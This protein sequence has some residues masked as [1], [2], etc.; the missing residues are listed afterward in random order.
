MLLVCASAFLLALGGLIGWNRWVHVPRGELRQIQLTNNS[1]DDPVT[2]AVISGDGKY[3]LYADNASIHI[4]SLETSETRDISHPSEFGSRH[5]S[6]DFQWFPDSVRFLAV[7]EGNTWQGSVING[8]L[9]KLREDANAW[10]ISPDASRIVFSPVDRR[11]QLWVMNGSGENAQL[12]FDAGEASSFESVQWS[13]DGTR[14]L[15]LRGDVS[16]RPVLALELR[17]L[18][19]SAPTVLLTDDRLRDLHW[20]RDGRILYLLGKPGLQGEVCDFWATRLDSRAASFAGKPEQ[21]T[22]SDG[23]CMRHASSTDDSR[24]LVF[25]RYNGGSTIE[26]ADLDPGGTRITP[27][28]H[29]SLLECPESPDG[30][31]ADSREVIF[32]SNC[33]QTR[34]VYRQPLAGGPAVPIWT[35][36]SPDDD[37]GIVT[38]SPDGNWIFY[39]RYPR[40]P[41]PARMEL[42]KSP[43]A[44]GEPS[45]IFSGSFM[46]NPRCSHAA[47]NLCAVASLDKNEL[48]FTSFDAV[49]GLGRELGRVPVD[50]HENYAWVLSPDG[51]RIA[52]RELGSAAFDLLEWKTGK[53][54]TIRVEGRT[55]FAGWTEPVSMDWAPDS[56]GLFMSVDEPASILLHVDLNGGATV[57]CEGTSLHFA[58]ASP[59][60]RHVAMQADTGNSNAW[61]IQNF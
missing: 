10:A 30:W 24:K 51:R 29:F 49:H 52:V 5:P 27:P 47:A 28:R 40:I 56:N 42:M 43:L 59:D 57:L 4:K 54:K 38:T 45:A 21:V 34:G 41:P 37:I 3:L 6:W 55:E 7:A 33:D 48:V 19:G 58:V 2:G 8:T 15:D 26:V 53:R 11:E 23:Y 32:T 39:F 9:R 31:T 12:L 17:D 16:G 22:H 25:S 14:L 60:G 18:K 20:L 35:K 13:P 46:D 36:H 1:G 50:P 44:G 61:M